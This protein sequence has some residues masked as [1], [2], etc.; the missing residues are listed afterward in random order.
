MAAK[1]A[2]SAESQ[3]KDIAQETRKN[4]MEIVNKTIEKNNSILEDR[5][6]TE[7]DNIGMPA[8]VS[9]APEIEIEVRE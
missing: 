5:E 2:G 8:I 9:G 7:N 4:V 3:D 6:L 1:Q